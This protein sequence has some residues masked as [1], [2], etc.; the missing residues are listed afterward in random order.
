MDLKLIAKMDARGEI[1]WVWH[2]RP[3]FTVAKPVSA[4]CDIAHGLEEAE[5]SGAGR[6][7]ILAWIT[8][9]L[10]D[11]PSHEQPNAVI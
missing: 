1:D 11:V 4:F 6:D 9:H 5:F 3:H 8:C 7:A 10:V 2:W